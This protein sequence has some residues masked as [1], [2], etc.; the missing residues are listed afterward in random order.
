MAGAPRGGAE[1]FYERL[2]RAQSRQPGLRVL[3]VIRA[4]P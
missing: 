2:V 3:P 1:L 4:E